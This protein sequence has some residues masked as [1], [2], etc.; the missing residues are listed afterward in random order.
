MDWLQLEEDTVQLSS[1]QRTIIDLQ[2][3]L[4]CERESWLREKSDMQRQIDE[5]RTGRLHDQHRV[6]ELSAQ[7]RVALFVRLGAIAF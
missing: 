3:K 1:L 4:Q 7:V 2:Y 5:H 6:A